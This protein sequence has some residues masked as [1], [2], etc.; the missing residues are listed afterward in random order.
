MDIGGPLPEWM[1]MYPLFLIVATCLL[2]NKIKHWV[3]LAG[4]LFFLIHIA[5]VLHLFP[6]IR[7][8][9]IADRYLYLSSIGLSFIAVYFFVMAYEKWKKWI[10]YTANILV[11]TFFVVLGIYTFKR[12][13]LWH[14]TKS[15][16]KELMPPE[17]NI[18]NNP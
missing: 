7:P 4:G 11:I 12:T 3:V 6:V 5:F 16:K 13:Q 8:N 10:Q 2:W 15:L 1:I 18:K 14:D 9:I 17:I